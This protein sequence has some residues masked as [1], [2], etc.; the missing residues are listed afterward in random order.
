MTLN[1]YKKKGSIQ[2][3]MILDVLVTKIRFKLFFKLVFLIFV[4]RV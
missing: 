3:R 1:N 2:K 4:D